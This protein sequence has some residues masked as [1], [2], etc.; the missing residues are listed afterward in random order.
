MLLRGQKAPLIGTLSMNSA[1]IDLT[2][3]PGAKIG[4]EVVVVGRQD[5]NE[6]GVNELANLSG[7]IG[8]ELMM[9][10]GR[11]IPRQYKMDSC[12]VS[13][14]ITVSQDK[15]DDVHFR[16]FDNEKELPE[17]LYVNDITEFLLDHMRP[18][19]DSTETTISAVDYALSAHPQGKGFV[20]VASVAK[21]IVGVIVAI[22]T[23]KLE[24]IPENV[25]VYV[26]VHRDYRHRGIGS[27]L[28]KEAMNCVEGNLKINVLK[29]N[30]ALKLLKKVGFKND[31]FEM[32]FEKGV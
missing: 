14:E 29:T 31:H 24:I 10:F 3:I 23:D 28:L 32:R 15:S 27:R 11:G 9:R 21:E 16:Y 13:T 2:D 25:L 5:E 18:Y 7:T 17:W 8:A 20:L 22:R 1:T 6:L 4:D 26:C 12:D 19:N 30:P